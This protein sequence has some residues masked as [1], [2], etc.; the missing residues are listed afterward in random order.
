[1]DWELQGNSENRE[2]AKELEE[3]EEEEGRSCEG[4]GELGEEK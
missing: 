2:S 4:D 1:M 3:E